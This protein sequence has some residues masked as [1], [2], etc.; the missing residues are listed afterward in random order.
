MVAGSNALMIEAVDLA[1]NSRIE[2]RQVFYE[3][4]PPQG[5]LLKV[6]GDLQSA[7]IRSALAQPLVVQLVDSE[8]NPRPGE[9]LAFAVARGNGQFSGGERRLLAVT[10]G[11]GQASVSFTLGSRA[12][13]GAHR[14]EATVAG[15]GTVSFS[16]TAEAG[17]PESLHLVS[18]DGQPGVPGQELAQ[19]LK[20]V[21]T[22]AGQNPVAG[23]EVTF[24]VLAGGGSFN[25]EASQAVLTDSKGYASAKLLLGSSLGIGAHQVEAYISGLG[26]LPV[27][28][29]ASAFLEGDPSETKLSGVVL[30]NAGVPVP[31]YTLS[32]LGSS[33]QAT[34]GPAGEFTLAG[35]PL[36]HQFLVADGSTASRPGTWPHLEF[37]VFLLS[38]IDNRMNR[39]IFV[40]PLDVASGVPAGGAEAAVVEVPQ[41][42]GFS[43][44][45]APGTV[46]FPDGAT[47]GVVSATAVQADKIPMAPPEGMQ[48]RFIVSIQPAGAVF[49]P[50]AP[51]T[52]QM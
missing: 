5:R 13:S 49:D 10:D 6:S 16:A 28:F 23:A 44:T 42:P 51:V 36:G 18:G 25:G 32:L 11:G 8:G 9:T 2:V 37:E 30:D 33:Q 45:V 35:V 40:L 24:E 43:L 14:V 4:T 47:E 50:P 12:G 27:L 1:G 3:P 26:Q 39:P 46:T 29:Q 31:G 52:F 21:V 48:P 19:P 7:S 38:G 17:S 41:V 20:V 15:V 34:S 22:D